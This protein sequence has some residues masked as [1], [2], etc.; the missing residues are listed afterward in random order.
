MRKPPALATWLLG[1]FGVPERNAALIGDLCEEFQEGKSSLWYWRQ[2]LVAIAEGLGH[3]VRAVYLTGTMLGWATWLCFRMVLWLAGAFR[4]RLHAGP[5]WFHFA[6]A[7]AICLIGA[8]FVKRTRLIQIAGNTFC[9]CLATDWV[10]S[11]FWDK[12]VSVDYLIG[13]SVEYLVMA[14]ASNLGPIVKGRAS[15]GR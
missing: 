14:L 4:F 13:E 5:L 3:S 1:R 9:F 2:A 11:D 7:M 6:V 10:I 15:R 12:P 8:F